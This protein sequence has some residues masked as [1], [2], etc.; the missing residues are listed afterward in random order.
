M[1]NKFISATATLDRVKPFSSCV[2]CGN[3]LVTSH[4][5]VCALQEKCYI[6]VAQRAESREQRLDSTQ[7]FW[8]RIKDIKAILRYR[9]ALFS[10]PP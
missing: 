7:M 6:V 10:G 1:I 9:V 5:C 3:V 8:A 4:Q 2:P